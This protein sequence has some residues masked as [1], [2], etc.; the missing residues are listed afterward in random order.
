M[1]AVPSTNPAKNRNLGDCAREGTMIT[2]RCNGCRR[3]VNFWA[4]DL[5]AVLG[6][7]HQAHVPPWPCTRCRTIEYVVMRSTYPS[8]ADLQAGITVRRPVRQ[9][10]KW[11]WRDERT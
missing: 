9:I 10:V 8:A 1:P 6:P 3:Q 2:M 4:T 7:N 11:L 5:V